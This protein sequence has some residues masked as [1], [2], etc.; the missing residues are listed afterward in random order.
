MLVYSSRTATPS[1]QF[2]VHGQL[3]LRGM[4]IDESDPK[5]AVPNGFTVYGGNRCL[6][7]SATSPEERSKWME[8]LTA[9]VQLAR[10]L[11]DDG[12]P[13]V[14]YP[15]LKSNSSS[16]CLD[17]SCETPQS[18]SSPDRQIQHR[19][20]TTMHVCWHRNTSVSM[21]D[22]AVAVEVSLPLFHSKQ[23]HCVD[24]YRTS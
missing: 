3:P 7:V 8:D 15:S 22:H 10:Q 11:P 6:L 12:Q 16:E 14:L 4:V 20:N 17:E 1:L 9:A 19:A 5:M 13:K 18:P 24:D 2:K 21:R 23:M